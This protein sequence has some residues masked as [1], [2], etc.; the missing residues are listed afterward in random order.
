MDRIAFMGSTTV[1]K[2][3]LEG[4][5]Q[6]LKKVTLEMG[7]NDSA[8]VC[9][10]VDVPSIIP[11]VAMAAFANTGQI[12]MAIR[13]VYIHESIYGYVLSELVKFVEEKLVVGDG[14]EEGTVL[15]PISHASQFKRVK[16]YLA[17]IKRSKLKI[18]TSSTKALVR[19]GFFVSPVVLDNP[20]DD[21]RA[22]V[23]ELFGMFHLQDYA[24]GNGEMLTIMAAP[25][26]P[27]LKWSDEEDVIRRANNTEHGL[28]ASVWSN[29]MVQAERISRQLEAGTIW[30]N[31]H[32]ELE[33]NVAFACHKSSG[34]GAAC[35]IEGMK[36]YCKVQS[37]FNRPSL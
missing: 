2:K 20:P 8:I 12:C 26:L 29:D 4:C 33:P 5:A 9:S 30:I 17:D 19:E 1:G 31:T 6:S 18:A 22:V 16:E 7:G 11:K 27:L 24:L 25:I 3:I 23:E 15:G 34:Y 37:I 36:S 21:S 35:G 13:R 32:G 10:D 28:G 14:F